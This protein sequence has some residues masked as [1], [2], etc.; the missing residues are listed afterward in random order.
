MM[1]NIYIGTLVSERTFL[2][3]HGIPGQKWGVRNGPPYPLSSTAKSS[4]EKKVLSKRGEQEYGDAVGCAIVLGAYL[5][6]WVAMAGAA[7]VDTAV[8]AKQEKK[9]AADL[10]RK[11]E[12]AGLKLDEAT[13]FYK[14]KKKTSIEEDTKKVNPRFEESRRKGDD[15]YTTNCMLCTTTL[16]MRRRGYEV[17]VKPRSA[18]M[19]TGSEAVKRWFPDAKTKM[20]RPE[21]N[22]T[23]Y[24]D[25]SKMKNKAKKDILSQG[26]GARGNLMFTWQGSAGAGHSVFYEVHN[27][28]I[29]I[30][31]TQCNRV[32]PDSNMV[33][34]RA[35]SIVVSRLD[36]VKFDPNTVKE[37]CR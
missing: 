2:E 35:S 29:T 10:N 25:Y 3:H 11:R 12:A 17:E 31:D 1:N 8:K 20:Y 21:G 14:K 28:K 22:D 34:D 30:I 16:E 32:L 19:Y 23:Y 7:A 36:N 26:E 27:K 5:L 33:F 13:G 4:A 15:R 37:C 18:G 24:R 6:P 9:Y